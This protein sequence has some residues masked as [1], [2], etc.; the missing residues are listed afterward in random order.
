MLTS[1]LKYINLIMFSLLFVACNSNNSSSDEEKVDSTI[2]EFSYKIDIN[3]TKVIWNG[4]KTNDKIKVVGFFKNFSSDRVGQEFTS[5]N[6]LVSGLE[7]SIESASST[8]GDEIRD[9][10]LK[11]HFFRYLTDDF[12]INGRLGNPKS[13]SIDVTF[14]VFGQQKKVRLGYNCNLVDGSS[15]HI[16]EIRGSIDLESQF[17]AYKA[18]NAISNKCYNLHKG[19]DGISR[20]WKQVDIYVKAL[21]IGTSIDPLL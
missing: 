12:F 21:V 20:T 14:L 1:K 5:I 7:F 8:S 2:K 6:E 9:T 17:G 4:Y 15:N 11:D 16:V 18:Y 19:S 13:D 3:N 10:N